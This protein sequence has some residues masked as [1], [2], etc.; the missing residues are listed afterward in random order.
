MRRALHAVWN[1]PDIELIATED[2]LGEYPAV[3]YGP[4]SG[5]IYLDVLTRLG[6]LASFDDLQSEIVELSGVPVR[7]ATPRTLFRLKR[8]TVRPIDK[9]TRRRCDRPSSWEM[10]KSIER[11][12]SAFD[13]P[14]PPLCPRSDRLA[15]MAAV[16]KRAHLASPPDPPRGVQKF[17]SLADARAARLQKTKERVQRIRAGRSE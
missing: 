13:M 8:D 3:R 4:P 17:R 12:R 14:R 16:W 1:D 5:A 2:P 7:V 6:D 10:M 9:P 15:R 11:F